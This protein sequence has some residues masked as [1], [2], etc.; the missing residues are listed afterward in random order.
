METYMPPN[1][2]E[3]RSQ[4]LALLS[5][6][7]HK[8]GTAPEIRKLLNIIQTSAEYQ[9]LGQVEKRNLCLIDKSYREQTALPEK[10]V[11]DLA[12]Q[13]ALTVNVWKKAKVQKN[14]SL[15]KADLQKLFDL[16]KQAAEILMKVKESK[17]PYEALID[18][19]EP[20]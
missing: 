8:L 14:F 5:R 15:Y 9:S 12:M 20:T 6:I 1:A 3:Q 13:E 18:N 16:S 4:Q 2:V 19:F 11:S 17:M 7:H 10:L